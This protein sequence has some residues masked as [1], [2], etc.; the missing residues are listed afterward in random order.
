MSDFWSGWITVIS[1]ANILACYWLIKWA[2]KPS[3]NEAAQGDVTGHKWDGDLEEYNNPLPRWWLWLFYFTIVFSLVYLVLYPGL[4][5]YKGTLNW[6][7]TGQY[8]EEIQH[9]KKTYDPIFA[10]FAKQDIATLAKDE[11]ATKVG[12]R[13]FLNYCATCHASDAGGARGFPNLADNDWLWG[14]EAAEIKTTISDGR[15][16][17]MPP[18]EAALGNDGVKNVT[19]YVISLSGRDHNA[20][21]AKAGKAQ[22]DMMCV[23]CHGADGKGN[24]AMGAPN[25]TD[26][27]WLYGGSAGVITQTIAKGRTGVMPAHGDFLGADKVHLLSAYIYSLRNQ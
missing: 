18:W 16:G 3:P 17:S 24:K 12:Q 2:S 11:N 6:S 5:N 27:V 19:Q 7:Q 26:N 21:A 13:L 25:L 22:F 4:G 1:L 10:E 8:D 15:I 14:G 20:E 23:A 9:A